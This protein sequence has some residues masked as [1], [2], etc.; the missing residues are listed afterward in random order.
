MRPSRRHRVQEGGVKR[1][2]V[3]DAVVSSGD[4]EYED[5]AFAP[6]EDDINTEETP[7]PI[8]RRM[9]DIEPREMTWLWPNRIPLGCITALVGKPGEGKSFLTTDI[10]ARVSTGSPWPDGCGIAPRGEVLM[11]AIEDDPEMTIRPRLDAH[12]ADPRRVVLLEGVR[13]VT[14][15]K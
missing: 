9:S 6:P 2:P 12:H 4:E 10:A 3:D 7:G 8:L 1:S 14:S 15:R 11:I 5:A 13:R